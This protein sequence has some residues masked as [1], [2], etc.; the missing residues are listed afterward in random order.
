MAL[1]HAQKRSRYSSIDY[2]SKGSGSSA[3]GDLC[4][5]LFLA[6]LAVGAYACWWNSKQAQ[7]L[8]DS[9]RHA[10]ETHLPRP[11][12]GGLE[13]RASLLQRALSGKLQEEDQRLRAD[14]RAARTQGKS[15]QEQLGG[16]RQQHESLE[17][18]DRALGAELDGARKGEA[19][20]HDQLA[21]AREEESNEAHARKSVEKE[22]A[23]AR[24][25]ASQE[26]RKEDSLRSELAQAEDDGKKLQSSLAA[27]KERYGA[28]ERSEK[29]LRDELDDEQ[30]WH[31]ATAGKIHNF[32]KAQIA[33]M[34]TLE[35]TDSS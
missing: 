15:L 28:A 33:L 9:V 11:D 17:S 27:L 4:C 29:Q 26:V 14:L 2:R 19:R 23:L 18:R 3:G 24:Q 22:L 10:V 32:R 1:S 21:A 7:A 16:L 34:Q 6:A 25:K 13:A 12:L 30:K 31:Q 35:A 8:Q 20:L 5:L